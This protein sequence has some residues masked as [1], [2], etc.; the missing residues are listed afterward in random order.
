MRRDQKRLLLGGRAL[1][2]GQRKIALGMEKLLLPRK[3]K[4]P[5]HKMTAVHQSSRFREQVYRHEHAASS[6]SQAQ[7]LSVE[8]RSSAFRGTIHAYALF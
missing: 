4:A 7:S 1:L 5:G 6:K 3:G 8:R 2:R